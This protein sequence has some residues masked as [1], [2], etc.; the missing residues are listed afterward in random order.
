MEKRRL[1]YSEAQLMTTRAV[2]KVNTNMALSC[3]SG[4]SSGIAVD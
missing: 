4:S 2:D 1:D 3:S